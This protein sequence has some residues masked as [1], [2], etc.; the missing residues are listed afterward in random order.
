MDENITLDILKE[1]I[2]LERRGNA[3]Y[4]NVADRTESVPLKHFF[5]N[6][7]DEETRHI[8]ILSEQFRSFQKHQKFVPNDFGDTD[9]ERAAS[10]VLSKE[11]QEKISAAGFEAA[12]ISAA[13]AMEERAIKLYA[14]RAAA[15]SNLE[16]RALY[17]WLAEWERS[18]LRLLEE[19]DRQLTEKIWFDNHFWPF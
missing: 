9:V 1:A 16:E 19:I 17:E 18:H 6:M 3:F 4:T 12:A 10:S 14:E 15:T 8:E 7:A 2:L 13:M 5:T 11:I